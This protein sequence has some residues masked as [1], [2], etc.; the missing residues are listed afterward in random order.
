MMT[1][2]HELR[3]GNVHGEGGAEWRGTKG[4][5]WDKCNSKINKI[6]I[7]KREHDG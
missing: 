1:H 4:E 5:N 6:Y 2:E 7:L 3:E